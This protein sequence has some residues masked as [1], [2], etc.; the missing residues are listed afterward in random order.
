MLTG[1]GGNQKSL[2]R[3]AGGPGRRVHHRLLEKETT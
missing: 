3:G 2:G 1:L